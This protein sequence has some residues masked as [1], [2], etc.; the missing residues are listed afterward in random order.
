MKKE[1]VAIFTIENTENI[2]YNNCITFNKENS[3]KKLLPILLI[4]VIL[5]LTSCGASNVSGKYYAD[6]VVRDYGTIVAEIDA[7]AAP[8]TAK[9]FI[10]LARDGFYDGL[11][12]HR[13]YAGFVIQGGDPEGT[14]YGGSGKKIKGEFAAN[15]YNNPISHTRGVISMARGGDDMNSASSQFFIVH[16][17]AQSS[18]DGL[19]AAFG[20]VIEGMEIVDAICED[21]SPIDGNGTILPSEQP[22]IESITIRDK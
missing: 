6:I 21:A 9:N 3:M 7:D 11:T 13:I 5:A 17:D 18:L 16:Q 2:C 19:Y 14:G 1:V 4:L 12:F 20:R 10:N 22:I 15:G 8:I